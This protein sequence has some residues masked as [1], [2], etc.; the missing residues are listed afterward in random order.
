MT[1]RAKWPE[2]APFVLL[3]DSLAADGRSTLFTEPREVLRCDAPEEVPA[4]LAR[5]AEAGRQGLYAAGFLAY[6]LGYLLEPKLSPLLPARRDQPLLWMGLF[7][8]AKELDRNATANGLTGRKGD[9]YDWDDLTLS[10][11][12]TGY[13]EA[14]DRVR[15]EGSSS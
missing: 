6:E 12:E 8:R 10:L 3:D 9:G 4:A 5:L 14:F 13:L 2:E 1:T 15:E 7:E 11:D